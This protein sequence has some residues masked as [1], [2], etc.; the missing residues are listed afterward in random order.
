MVNVGVG[1]YRMGLA[2]SKLRPLR[3]GGY[4]V[5]QQEWLRVA[6]AIWGKT[7]DENRG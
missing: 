7:P 1:I 5:P 2:E 3:E 4:R 6:G